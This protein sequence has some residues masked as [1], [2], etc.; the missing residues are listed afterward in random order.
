MW[1]GIVFDRWPLEYRSKRLEPMLVK[2]AVFVG[3]LVGTE[4]FFTALSILNLRHGD[5]TVRSESDWVTETLGVADIDRLLA[6]NRLSIGFGLL[7]TWIGLGAVLLVLYSGLFADA[8]GA[9]GTLGLGT[10]G[11]GVVFLL[12]VVVATILLSLPFDVVG[13]FG[14]EEAFDFNRQSVP[15]WLRDQVVGLGISIVIGGILGTAILWFLSLF[16]NW[17]WIG[18]WGLFVAFSLTM[19]V[20]YPRVIAPLFYDF[21]PIEDGPVRE[22]VDDTFEK[23]GFECEQVYE[24]DASRRSAKSNAY[25]IGFGR[26]KRVV[27]FDTLLEGMDLPSIQGVLAHELAHWKKAHNN[28]S[29]IRSPFWRLSAST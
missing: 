20:I 4:V 12:G 3:L 15:L 16:P 11:N 24:M 9:V 17:W 22:S 29:G 10:V 18:A 5:R 25:F 14:I 13:T 21:D 8:V 1:K 2:H 28:P 6:Y 27:L 7:E 26:T 23:A 19:M